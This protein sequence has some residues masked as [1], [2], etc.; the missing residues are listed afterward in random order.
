[1]RGSAVSPLSYSV[2]LTVPQEEKKEESGKV[3]NDSGK[4]IF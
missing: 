2:S 4:K 1:M 3:R